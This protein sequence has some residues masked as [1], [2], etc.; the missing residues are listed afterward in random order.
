MV[1]KLRKQDL[2]RIERMKEQSYLLSS[3]YYAFK[4]YVLGRSAD[5]KILEQEWDRFV[6]ELRK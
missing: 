6:R 5:P 3:I 4:R 1:I 2:T